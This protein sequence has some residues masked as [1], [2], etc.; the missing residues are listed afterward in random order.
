L[1]RLLVQEDAE[2]SNGFPIDQE[3]LYPYKAIVI[4]DLEAE[5]FSPDQQELLETFVAK[6]GGALLF[7]G[8]TES[9]ADGGYEDSLLADLLPVYLGRGSESVALDY[10]ASM[11][12]TREGMLEFWLRLRQ[13]E[14]QEKARLRNM[15]SFTNVNLVRSTKPGASLFA[16]VQDDQTG[17]TRPALAVQRFG[18]GKVGALTIGD[19]WRWG[20]LEPNQAVDRNKSWRQLMRHLTV[21]APERFEIKVVSGEQ[22]P[23]EK[24]IEVRL[25][26]KTFDP[27]FNAK[28]NLTVT[29]PTGESY[30]FSANPDDSEPGLYQGVFL[31]SVDGGY[32]V[33]AEASPIEDED[34]YWEPVETGWSINRDAQEFARLDI[35]TDWI[36]RITSE[37]KGAVIEK[38]KVDRL[39]KLIANTEIEE[40]E[41]KV[42]PIWHTPWLLILAI[43]C[44]AG[45]W[46]IRRNHGLA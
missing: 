2:L 13:L 5:F 36:N 43:L 34:L 22:D 7:L 12:L 27:Q 42:T 44:F 25:K 23:Q 19:M 11:G 24:R 33:K 46:A 41:I 32:R 45:E 3:E 14:V 28:I 37:T 17:E 9:F 16:T 29:D 4:D 39:P 6:R 10:Q 21:D 20:F 38:D 1:I 15:A 40:I 18:S 8:G 31:A 35:N 30:T 26:N